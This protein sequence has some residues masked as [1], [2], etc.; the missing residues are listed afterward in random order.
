MFHFKHFSLYHDR[1]TLKIGTD[2]VLLAS[3]VPVK[4]AT[5]ILDIGCGC[6]VITF[7]LSYRKSLSGS[8]SHLTGI[9]IDLHSV[10]EARLNR[11]I[12]PVYPGQSIEFRLSSLQQ[13]TPLHIHDYDLIVTNPPYFSL[14]LKPQSIKN[15]KSKHRDHLLSFEDLIGNVCR[16]LSE[17][18]EFY[19]I[20]PPA[21]SEEF[22]KKA[23]QHLHLFYTCPIYPKP[24][25][26]FH[27]IISGYSKERREPY[28][29]PALYIRDVN[30]RYTI[31]YRKV[32]ES[33]YLDLR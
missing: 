19:L 1:S 30:N 21:E 12:F 26:P 11:K 31:D 17:N 15:L 9:D 24:G 33:F 18:G 3:V 20:L 7:C 4:K 8:P 2:S 25:K 5:R 29:T 14:S 13:Y 27:R 23:Q 16:L 32:T 22:R 6:G 28:I 10:E